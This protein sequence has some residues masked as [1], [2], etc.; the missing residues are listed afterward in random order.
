[1]VYY[2]KGIFKRDKVNRNGKKANTVRVTGLSVNSKFDDD[3]ELIIMATEELTKLEAKIETY[4]NT[5]RDLENQVKELENIT[6]APITDQKYYNELLTEKDD[7]ANLLST[8]NNRN[9]LLLGTQE[10]LNN[11]VDSF[12]NDITELY[13]TEIKQAKTD[14]L[15]D[16]QS[17]TDK[18]KDTVNVL[19]DYV[20]EL[21]TQQQKHNNT[22]DNSS[23]YKR[24]FSKDTFKM[25]LDTGKLDG[26]EKDLSEIKE[27][28][29][30]YED[31][32]KPVE[33]P[34]SRISEIKLNAKSNKLDIKELYID[35]SE[36]E[37][38]E[39][40]I[41]ITPEA[42]NNGNDN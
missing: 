9:G 20:N 7:K 11:M 6:P 27:Y 16:L 28:C 24:A 37:S 8:I 17:K 2:E 1:M 33:I 35:T 31:I 15:K 34:A 23:W 30:N 22:V 32:V 29:I 25:D 42:V 13:D 36:L 41:T 10:A 4:K 40:N 14:T 5:I 21:E 26:I 38:N 12:T 3:D 19:I 39:D 18:I